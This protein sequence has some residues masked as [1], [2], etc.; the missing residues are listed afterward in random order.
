M[1]GVERFLTMFSF[2]IGLQSTESLFQV[3]WFS[4]NAFVLDC[5]AWKNSSDGKVHGLMHKNRN[6]SSN[7]F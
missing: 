1:A 7:V 2:K 5:S 4:H 6:I 3:M